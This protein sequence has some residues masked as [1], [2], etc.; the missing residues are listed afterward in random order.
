MAQA[1][2]TIA[3]KETTGVQQPDSSELI[4]YESGDIRLFSYLDVANNFANYQN[5]IRSLIPTQ[6]FEYYL[7]CKLTDPYHPKSFN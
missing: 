1:D 3:T 4:S 2:S 5:N 7:K 6:I